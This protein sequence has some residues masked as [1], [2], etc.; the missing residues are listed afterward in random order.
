VD[1][2]NAALQSLETDPAAALDFLEKNPDA[3]DRPGRTTALRMVALYNLGRYEDCAELL[4]E[5]RRAGTDIGRMG[6]EFPRFGRMLAQERQEH[7]LPP[8]AIP[9][10]P[11][12]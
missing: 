2:F 10:G 9:A 12:R 7:H 3:G 8:G 6:R 1:S 4:G 11:G 5:A